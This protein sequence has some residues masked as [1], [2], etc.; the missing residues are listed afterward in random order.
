LFNL[1]R[2]G[3]SLGTALRVSRVESAQLYT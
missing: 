2:E 3:Q 1:Q